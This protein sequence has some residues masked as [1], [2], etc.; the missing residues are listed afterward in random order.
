MENCVAVLFLR[1]RR[2][3]ATKLVDHRLHTIANAK[4]GDV[5]VINPGRRK[6]SAIVVYAG[7][8]ARQYDSFGI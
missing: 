5:A 6:G 3:N 4:Y 7:R 2:Y 8:T 1:R